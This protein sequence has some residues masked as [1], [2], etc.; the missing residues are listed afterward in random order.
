[1]FELQQQ[2]HLPPHP[3]P[4]L[5]TISEGKRG[6]LVRML[7]KW[8]KSV[9]ARWSSLRERASERERLASAREEWESKFKSVESQ[10]GVDINQ[11]GCWSYVPCVNAVLTAGGEWRGDELGGVSGEQ[12]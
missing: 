2:Q 7:A 5:T 3:A 6:S 10:P 1:M 9:E 8:K 11:G 4:A 12:E